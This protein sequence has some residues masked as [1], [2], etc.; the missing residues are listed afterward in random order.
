VQVIADVAGWYDAGNDATGAKFHPVT[1]ARILDDRTGN[2]APAGALGAGATLNLQAS[3]RAGLPST[4]V[5]GVVLNVAVTQPTAPS[6]LTVFPSGVV[7][8][9]AAS[10]NFVPNQTVS[11][12]VVAKVGANGQVS[13]YN[14]AGATYVIADVAG[15]FDGP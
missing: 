8:P 3:G 5:S 14:A 11:N 12:L 6:Y 2:G 9:L 15:W 4:G 7:M 10:L 13:I 1:P